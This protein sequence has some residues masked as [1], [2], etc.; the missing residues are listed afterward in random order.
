MRS[1]TLQSGKLGLLMAAAVA[2]A[3][4]SFLLIP[5]PQAQAQDILQQQGNLA[6][7]RDEYTFT[8]G[9]GQAVHIS[10]TSDEFDTLLVLVDANNQEIAFNDDYGRTLNSTIIAVLPSNG[11]YKVWAR[12][13]SGQ[14]GNYD[15]VVRDATSYEQAAHRGYGLL[16]ED[17]LTEAI[18]AYTEAIQLDPN[19]PVAYLE[20]AD[21]QY[22]QAYQRP[23]AP[24]NYEEVFEL[25]PEQLD[26]ILA[27]YQ[28]AVDLYE[29]AGEAD[30]AASIREQMSYLQAE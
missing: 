2:I 30:I 6:P 18:A 7:M 19:Q 16:Q 5:T 22:R 8:G 3:G 14:G 13:F 24:E 23:V 26:P 25:T 28:R 1:W 15:L 29:Q 9:A 20:R 12:S 21:A 27:D 17:K 10:M 4:S 11:V